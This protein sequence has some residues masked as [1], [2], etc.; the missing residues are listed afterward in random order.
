MQDFV[1]Q[2]YGVCV[3]RGCFSGAFVLGLKCLGGVAKAG[4]RKVGIDL[5]QP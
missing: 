4:R 5:E 1:H 2:Q 3:T